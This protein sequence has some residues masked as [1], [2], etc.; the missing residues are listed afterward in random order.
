MWICVCDVGYSAYQ[1]RSICVSLD[2]DRKIFDIAVAADQDRGIFVEVDW[3]WD[4]DPVIFA[5]AV[6][7]YWGNNFAECQLLQHV[8]IGGYCLL[9]RIG[10]GDFCGCCFRFGGFSDLRY[11]LMQFRI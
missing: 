6:D 10:I 3:D 5:V 8:L 2:R 9:R 7:C 11:W 4:R 1:D